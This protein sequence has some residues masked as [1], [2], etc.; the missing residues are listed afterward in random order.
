[1][2]N[3]EFKYIISP[4]GKLKSKTSSI[5]VDNETFQ[6]AAQLAKIYHKSIPDTI[7]DLLKKEKNFADFKITKSVKK[8][9]GILK[10]DYDYKTLRTM[11]IA[12]K[13]EKYESID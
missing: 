9:S 2:K 11:C 5:T 7:K 10:T 8:I 12:E 13:M 4:G 3:K 1:L 6:L